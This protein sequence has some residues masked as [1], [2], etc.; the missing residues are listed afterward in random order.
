MTRLALAALLSLAAVSAQADAPTPPLTDPVVIRAEAQASS[1]P[2][3]A[4]VLGLS[5][6]IVF[7]AALTAN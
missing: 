3:A 6:M 2:S 4:L 7:G 5:T 1:A